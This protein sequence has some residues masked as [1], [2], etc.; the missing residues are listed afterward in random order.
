MEAEDLWLTAESDL[1]KSPRGV[2]A[3]K[4]KVRCADKECE[5]PRQTGTLPDG[6]S[7]SSLY[8]Q[9]S[10]FAD[11]PSSLYEVSSAFP[12]T[13]SSAVSPSLLA[14]PTLHQSGIRV[15]PVSIHE[16]N[17]TTS[18]PSHFSSRAEVS[19][20]AINL[21]SLTSSNDS[22]TL[23]INQEIDKDQVY[24]AQGHQ[25]AP[26]FAESYQGP[27]DVD[28]YLPRRASLRFVPPASST[29]DWPAQSDS[30]RALN[31]ISGNEMKNDGGQ[32]SDDMNLRQAKPRSKAAG[33]HSH[34]D[35]HD[36]TT[37]PCCS[38]NRDEMEA[39]RLEVAELRRVVERKG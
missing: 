1:E 30:R 36:H 25:L 13:S 22:N 8:S 20:S 3:E 5:R 32:H 14:K 34:V 31:R 4:R 12:N 18:S 37:C 16:D 27:V 33:P 26:G 2:R 38:R 15:P 39:L 17:E 11:I 23:T 28:C 6:L 29:L 10:E 19:D 21:I 35:D 24:S 9:A 7:T